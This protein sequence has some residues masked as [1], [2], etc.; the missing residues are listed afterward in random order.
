MAKSMAVIL[1]NYNHQD[2]TIKCI[3][4]L[5]KCKWGIDLKYFIVDNS[6]GTT[7]VQKF[8]KIKANI[9]YYPQTKNNGFAKGINTGL[10]IALKAGS[11]YF[12]IINPDVLVGS[13]FPLLL[14]NFKHDNVGIVA[15]AIRHIQNKKTMYG[16]DGYVDWKYAKATHYNTSNLKT[17]SIID[18]EFVTFACVILSRNTIKKVGFIDERYF[19]YCEDVD[20]CLSAKQKKLKILLDSS[21][22]VDHRTSSSFSRPTQKLP[23]SFVSQIKFIN[24]W[25]PFSKSFVPYIYHI[26]GYMY[27]YLLWTYHHAKN[28]HK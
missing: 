4:A 7:K 23:I 13:D 28:S 9:L 26:F 5:Q 27:L 6:P 17:K 25:L 12:L 18:A 21:I 1:L 8:K 16:L 14:K 3:H 10:K 11:D 19:M 22:V 20:Y 24:K 15:P 2:D